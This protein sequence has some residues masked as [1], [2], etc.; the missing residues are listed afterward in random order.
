MPGF[1]ALF[2]RDGNVSYELNRA[3]LGVGPW[4]TVHQEFHDLP[5]RKERLNL[6][7]IGN[8]KRAQDQAFGCA[9]MDHGEMIA[10]V[11]AVIRD[12]GC[13]VCFRMQRRFW[14]RSRRG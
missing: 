6:L 9:F 12:N 2:L 4:D 13:A 5:L 3:I 1:A 7:G 11:E 8:L 14:L 10:T